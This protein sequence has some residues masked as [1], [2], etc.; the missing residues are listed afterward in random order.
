[1]RFRMGTGSTLLTAAGARMLTEQG[2]LRLDSPILV[3][4]RES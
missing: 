2:K 3:D 1:M 4:R